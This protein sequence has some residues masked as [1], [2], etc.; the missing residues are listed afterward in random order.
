MNNSFSG[1]TFYPHAKT[2]FDRFVEMHDH[3]FA[4]FEKKYF[5]LN[6]LNRYGTL[7]EILLGINLTEIIIK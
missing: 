1:L 2:S 3:F 7:D 5:L 4:I 6:Y